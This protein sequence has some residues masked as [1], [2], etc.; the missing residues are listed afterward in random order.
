M[1]VH[2]AWLGEPSLSAKKAVDCLRRASEGC[3]VRFHEDGSEV[4]P[5]WRAAFNSLSGNPRMQSDLLRH[6][7]LR[8]YGGLWL[9]LDVTLAV[10][11]KELVADWSGYTLLRLVPGSP[12]AATDL[13]YAQP[14]WPGWHLLDEYVAGVD[15]S[16]R[17]SHLAFAHD[18][19][20]WAFRRGAPVTL[21]DNATLYPCRK[22]DVTCNALA[23]RCGQSA[24]SP[25]LGDIVAA[26]LSA[27]GI[28]PERV[29]AALGVEDCGCK[30]RQA[31]LN[32]LGRKF[33]IG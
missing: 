31:K 32:E 11:P 13:I 25:G 27:V 28:T 6:S 24:A 7:L 20:L 17:L 12:W 2:T 16:V 4:W 3:E 19:I 21:L 22:R 8:R 1:I 29:S 9:D 14:D 15:T 26:G 5:A 23:L 18:M 30:K 10:G 33:G